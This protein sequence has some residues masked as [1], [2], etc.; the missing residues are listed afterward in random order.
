MDV[1]AQWLLLVLK[2]LSFSMITTL[3]EPKDNT[4]FSHSVFY[5]YF[6]D[7]LFYFFCLAIWQR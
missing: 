5:K 2:L 1:S 6:F 7:F 4:V 3:Y